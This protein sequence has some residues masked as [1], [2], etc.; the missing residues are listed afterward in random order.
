MSKKFFCFLHLG[1]AWI[2]VKLTALLLVLASCTQDDAQVIQ[3][4]SELKARLAKAEEAAKTVPAPIRDGTEGESP[5]LAA[6]QARIRDLEARLAAAESR[7]GTS[8][9]DPILNLQEI[10]RKMQADLITKTEEL[11][12][13]VESTAPSANIQEITVRRIKPP[14]EIASAFSSAIIF[15]ALDPRQRSLRLEFPVQ[16]NLDGVW[17]LP[18]VKDIERS[19]DEA[20]ASVGTS[21]PQAG[22][23][24]PVAQAPQRPASAPSTFRQVDDKTFQFSWDTARNSPTGPAATSSA[25]PPTGAAPASPRPPPAPAPAQPTIPKP[26]MPVV[27]D[28]PI[29]FE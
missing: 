1:S 14:Q 25:T 19:Y 29:R 9:S 13:L 2:G 18:T 27:Q 28:V 15:T 17:K 11:R 21:A 3:Q 5:A 22:A 16:A 8:S 4:L 20:L 24:A 12:S 26:L 7:G 6:A 23:S 10:A